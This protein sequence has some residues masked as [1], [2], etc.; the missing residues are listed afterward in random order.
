MIKVINLAN[1]IEINKITFPSNSL[2]F[3]LSNEDLSIMLVGSG[4]KLFTAHYSNYVNSLDEVY[5][6]TG[7]LMQDLVKNNSVI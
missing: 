6:N 7:L 1:G 2:I 5:L 3:E 4:K